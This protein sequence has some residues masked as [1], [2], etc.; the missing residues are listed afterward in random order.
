M[1]T[2]TGAWNLAYLSHDFERT[3]W[4]GDPQFTVNVR[5]TTQMKLDGSGLDMVMDPASEVLESLLNLPAP[6]FVYLISQHP[7]LVHLPM[8]LAY[9][10]MWLKTIE[11]R[12]FLCEVDGYQSGEIS[13]CSLALAELERIQLI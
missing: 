12:S 8:Y 7:L 5:R 11:E 3:L 13:D 2:T 10:H 4:H 6:R 1:L 9:G